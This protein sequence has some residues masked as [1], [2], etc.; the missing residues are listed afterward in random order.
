MKKNIIII[1][2][3]G[4][5]KTSLM[6]KYKDTHN[7]YD[8]F[9][10]NMMSKNFCEDVKY[11]NI[12][13]SD[14]RL[15]DPKKFDNIIRENFKPDNTLLILYKPDKEQCLENIKLRC[16]NT[17][18]EYKNVIWENTIDKFYKIYNIEYYSDYE[19]EILDVFKSNNKHNNL[20]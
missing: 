5:G 12:C 2:L 18:K 9:L 20:L 17:G 7:L 4:S 1:G 16:K 10:N 6:K 14:P 8:D 13:I 11:N 3:P 15:C 19:R